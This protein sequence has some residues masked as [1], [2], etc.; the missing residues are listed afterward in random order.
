MEGEGNDGQESCG[1]GDHRATRTD[2]KGAKHGRCKE[3]SGGAAD[4]A[5]KG[6]DGYGGGGML[7]VGVDK[8]IEKGHE[9]ELQGSREE[10]TDNRGGYPVD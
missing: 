3:R 4:G 9:D 2:A 7:M 8:V 1:S 5:G 6:V 10:S